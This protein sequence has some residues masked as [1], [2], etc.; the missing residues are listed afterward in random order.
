MTDVLRQAPPQRRRNIR[1][2]LAGLVAPALV[3]CLVAAGL[4]RVSRALCFAFVGPVICRVETAKPLV[5]LTFDDGPTALGVQNI[6]PELQRQGA[7]ATFFVVGRDVR[8]QPE[9]ARRILAAGHELGNHS[10]SHR[11]MVWRSQAFYEDEIAKTELEIRRVGGA[12]HSVR[13]PYARKL[14]GAPLAARRAG[15]QMV[16][17]DIEDP[18]TSD[19][20]AFA[21]RIVSAARP[22][23]IILLHAMSPEHETARAAL[24]AILAGLRSRGLE[25]VSV[26]QLIEAART[27]PRG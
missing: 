17:W 8:R 20:A 23:S 4:Q 11:M 6:L 24:P 12:S 16:L 18:R 10:F 15:L 26:Q 27:E 3:V 7:H 9:L 21:D 22:G 25:V 19:P 5:A 2:V 14:I 13:P 1:R